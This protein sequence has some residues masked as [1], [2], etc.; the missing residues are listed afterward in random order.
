MNKF[1]YT[2]LFITIVFSESLFAAPSVQFSEQELVFS[3]RMRSAKLSLVNRGDVTSTVT[4]D[5]LQPIYHERQNEYEIDN[6]NTHNVKDI[7]LDYFPYNFKIPVFAY[8]VSGEYSLI[9]NEIK[10]KIINKKAINE[11][12]ISF[13]RAGASAIVT[14]FADRFLKN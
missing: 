10:N 7:T 5:F 4:L 12:L 3:G 14:Y 6:F 11:S 2:I 9:M 1:F 13:K 8:Q